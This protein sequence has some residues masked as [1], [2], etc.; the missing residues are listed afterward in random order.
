M[1]YLRT[2]PIRNAHLAYPVSPATAHRHRGPCSPLATCCINPRC[3]LNNP[4]YTASHSTTSLH[5]HLSPLQNRRAIWESTTYVVDE[6]IYRRRICVQ[7]IPSP[8][9]QDTTILS[10]LRLSSFLS[11]A[12]RQI[13]ETEY[14]DGE[15]FGGEG[16]PMMFSLQ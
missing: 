16:V 7:V 3:T 13:E 2:T 11:N 6:V 12:G 5:L 10:L 8:K 1:T 9:W 14:T 15:I 4:G